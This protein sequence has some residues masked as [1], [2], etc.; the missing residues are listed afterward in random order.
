MSVSFFFSHNIYLHFCLYYIYQQSIFISRSAILIFIIFI[1]V[2]IIP[3]KKIKIIL[4]YLPLIIFSSI[5]S[6]F[7]WR[8]FISIL[9]LLLLRKIFSMVY[10]NKFSITFFIFPFLFHLFL[11]FYFHFIFYFLIHFLFFFIF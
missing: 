5:I 3:M 8:L 11:S 10:I 6:I 9:I 2:F 7:W 1:S 4:S